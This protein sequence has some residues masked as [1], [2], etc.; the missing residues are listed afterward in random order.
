M[1]AKLQLK[2]NSYVRICC[3]DKKSYKI[4]ILGPT[5]SENTAENTGSG[6]QDGK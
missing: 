2:N 1:T 3:L 5:K 4:K 6:F